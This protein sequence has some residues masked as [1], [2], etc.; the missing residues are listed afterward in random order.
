[1][2]G[3]AAGPGGSKLGRAAERVKPGRWVHIRLLLRL[4]RQPA[5]ALK[6]DA[7][8]VLTPSLAVVWREFID[9]LA[10]SSFAPLDPQPPRR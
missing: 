1:M 10:K 4:T 7:D 8:S 2:W 5:C 3:A 9:S 6:A